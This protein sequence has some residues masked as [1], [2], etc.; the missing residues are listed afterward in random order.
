MYLNSSF[1]IVVLSTLDEHH[2]EEDPG[3][4]T[5]NY[6]WTVQQE[7]VLHPYANYH[8]RNFQDGGWGSTYNAS[9]MASRKIF[10]FHIKPPPP[11]LNSKTLYES[12]PI[13]P[14]CGSI[15][16]DPH[17]EHPD[18]GG[19]EVVQLDQW[20]WKSPHPAPSDLIISYFAIYSFEIFI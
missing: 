4:S 20:K 13:N 12:S 18:P 14:D 5:K 11:P 1:A 10:L 6:H 15:L 17:K 8:L 3:F 7:K 2:H 9:L 16:A 19:T